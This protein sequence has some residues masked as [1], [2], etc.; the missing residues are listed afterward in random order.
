MLKLNLSLSQRQRKKFYKVGTSWSESDPA[1]HIV[2]TFFSVNTAPQKARVV[3]NM[4]H[5]HPCPI[6]QIEVR[7]V[8]KFA[9]FYTPVS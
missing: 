4:Y 1:I 2:K 9:R 8:L 5:F 3:V 6:F 7:G